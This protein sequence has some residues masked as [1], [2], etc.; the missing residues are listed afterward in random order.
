MVASVRVVPR[1]RSSVT[2]S[3]VKV[4]CATRHQDRERLGEIVTQWLR[5]RPELVVAYVVVTQSSDA[6]FHC[7]AISMFYFE[8]VTLP[9]V[10]PED[11]D[12][13]LLVRCPIR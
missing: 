8:T 9:S 11:S 3:G 1:S 5:E 4:F 6:E 2:F 10:Q 7:I 12:K 13:D